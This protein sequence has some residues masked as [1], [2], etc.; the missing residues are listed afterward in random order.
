MWNRSHSRLIPLVSAISFLL[1]IEAGGFQLVLTDIAGEFALNNTKMGSVVMAEYMAIILFPLIF[2]GISDKIGKKKVLTFFIP[3]LIIGCAIITFSYHEIGLYLGI[4]MIGA[5][6]AISEA[7]GAAA[8][9]DSDVVNSEKNQTFTQA[10]Y[11]LGAVI[12]PLI[13]DRL[14]RTGLNWRIGFI[15]VGI[16][17]AALFIFLLHT[18]FVR[19]DRPDANHTTSKSI[20][21]IPLKGTKKFPFLYGA[22]ILLIASAVIYCGIENGVSYFADS[23]FISEMNSPKLSVYAI[24]LFWLAMGTSRFIFGIIKTD[25]VKVVMILYAISCILLLL[26]SRI[27]TPSWALIL[28]IAMGF[29]CGPTCP[30]L[31]GMATK[32]FSEHSGSV[33]SILMSGLGLGGAISPLFMGLVADHFGFR[34]SFGILATFALIGFLLSFTFLR[35]ANL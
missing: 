6:Y 14:M 8:L 1:G 24:S 16:G 9:S 4:F 12:G 13:V 5:G 35:K 23:F 34:W 15:L 22:F 28:F 10:F 11:C 20:A 25:A 27:D 7:I 29:A 32:R 18:P 2:G 21:P 33:V 31:M 30:M 17:F 19:G 26:L 3:F